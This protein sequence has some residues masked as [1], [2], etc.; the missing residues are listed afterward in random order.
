ME[1]PT[2]HCHECKEL[3]NVYEHSEFKDNANYKQEWSVQ[4]I[5]CAVHY[6]VTQTR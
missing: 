2:V 6:I 4:C 3:M 1:K 5:E